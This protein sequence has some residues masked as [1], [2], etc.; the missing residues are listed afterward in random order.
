MEQ[1]ITSIITAIAVAFTIFM[2]K[3]LKEPDKKGIGE[4]FSWVKML[5]TLVIGV[6]FG[7]LA[8][9]QGIQITAENWEAYVAAN[10]GAIMI[11]D[12]LV[13]MLWR[14]VIKVSALTK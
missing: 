8:H 11:T 1:L 12:M 4:R 10:G 7:S 5:R 14:G 6:V 13:K 3:A 2:G 9:F